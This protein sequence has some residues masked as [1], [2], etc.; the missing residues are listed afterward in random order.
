MM[1]NI[2]SWEGW[3]AAKHN[4]NMDDV[5]IYSCHWEEHLASMRQVLTKFS[6]ADLTVNVVK[7]ETG[8]AWVM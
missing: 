7:I 3:K 1:I 4:I 8:H 2:S 6:D 5:L